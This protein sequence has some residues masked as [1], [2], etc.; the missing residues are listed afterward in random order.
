MSTRITSLL[1]TVIA[2]VTAINASVP[3]IVSVGAGKRVAMSLSNKGEKQLENGDVAGVKHNVDAAL[4][5]DPKYW[6]ALYQRAEIF[7]M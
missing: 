4:Q 7:A 3:I 6:P 2:S 5:A 1:I